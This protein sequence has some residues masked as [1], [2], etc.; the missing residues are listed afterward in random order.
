MKG[1]QRQNLRLH[2]RLC[3]VMETDLAK[4]RGLWILAYSALSLKE[5]LIPLSPLVNSYYK[6][7][8]DNM[9]ENTP[10]NIKFPAKV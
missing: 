1:V 3:D 10:E 7:K 8:C 4:N 9:D 2:Q 6:T 5:M